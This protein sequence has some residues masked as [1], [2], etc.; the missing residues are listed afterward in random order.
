MAPSVRGGK[1]SNEKHGNFVSSASEIFIGTVL[2]MTAHSG[3]KDPATNEMSEMSEMS[4]VLTLVAEGDAGTIYHDEQSD[5]WLVDIGFKGITLYFDREEF[6]L[7]LHLL[8]PA[9]G[10][11]WDA[12]AH[13]APQQGRAPRLDPPAHPDSPG[14]HDGRAGGE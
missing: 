12:D 3:K 9:M 8:Q 2:A 14:Q 1:N 5:E 4:D 10:R 7:F 6:Q 11:A 13:P